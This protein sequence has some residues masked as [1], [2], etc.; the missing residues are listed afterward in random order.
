[1]DDTKTD[2]RSIIYQNNE[3]VSNYTEIISILDK[4]NCKYT[5]NS[6]GIFINLTT[7]SDDVIDAIYPFFLNNTL[8]TYKD[9]DLQH[10]LT[11]IKENY[12][13]QTNNHIRN[14]SKQ[15]YIIP[16]EEFTP[17]E[18]KIIRASNNYFL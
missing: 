13:Q 9:I 3:Y 5:K 7:L 2:K 1:M 4:H 18:K 11:Q 17:Q 6:N 12:Q 14:V 10:E 15:S 16:I 8:E